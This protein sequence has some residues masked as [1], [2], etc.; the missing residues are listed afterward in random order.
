M[1]DQTDSDLLHRAKAGKQDAFH[2]LIDRHAPALL[3][4]ALTQ[5]KTHHDA[6]DLLQETFTAAFRSLH[7][8]E[9]RSTVKTWLY[10]ILFRQA[11]NLRRKQDAPHSVLHDDI[12]SP[13]PS[14]NHRTDARLD[15]QS[16]LDQ[17]PQDARAILILR[18]ID[19]LSYEEIAILLE[20]PKGTVESR[21]S[22]ARQS[23]KSLLLPKSQ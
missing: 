19:G 8:F 16:A 1:Q 3:R 10:A 17:L 23:L 4:L 20:L 11:S 18:E 6:E 14:A 9:E 5:T 15:L 21:L 13:I 7:T 2:R 22:R 12:P